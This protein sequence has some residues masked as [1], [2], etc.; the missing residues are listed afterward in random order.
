MHQNWNF[1]DKVRI[2]SVEE[3]FWW[4]N[5]LRVSLARKSTRG[6]ARRIARSYFNHLQVLKN[7]TSLMKYV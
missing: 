3:G 6:A 4:T 5:R 1:S 7:L 2:C